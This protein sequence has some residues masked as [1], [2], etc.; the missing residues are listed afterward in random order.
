M[1][2][3]HLSRASCLGCALLSLVLAS[4]TSAQQTTRYEYDA[5]GRLVK[6]EREKSDNTVDTAEYTY[7]AADNR[8]RVRTEKDANG[9]GSNDPD[10]PGNGT[11][12]ELRIVFNGRFMVMQKVT[13]N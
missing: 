12:G 3:L 2:L 5:L 6:V 9:Q 8:V 11:V 7:D 13:A 1:T 4:Q 10:P